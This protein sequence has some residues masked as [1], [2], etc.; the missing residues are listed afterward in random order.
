MKTLYV[1]WASGEMVSYYVD[2]DRWSKAHEHK[3][4][5]TLDSFSGTFTFDKA[6]KKVMLDTGAEVREA[7]VKHWEEV[8]VDWLD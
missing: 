2:K 8:E 4:C 5:F 1:E 6:T 7:K 3:D